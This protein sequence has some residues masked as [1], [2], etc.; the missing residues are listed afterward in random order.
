ML[1]DNHRIASIYQFLKHIHQNADVFEM[2]TGGWLIQD[3]ERLAGITFGKFGSKFHS[4]AFSARKG[5]GALSQL[6][7]T[8]SYTL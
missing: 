8:Q 2:K 3:V 7:V 1:D 4:L 6:D 5:S